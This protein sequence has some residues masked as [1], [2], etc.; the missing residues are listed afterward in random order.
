MQEKLIAFV[1]FTHSTAFTYIL[2]VCW[3][4]NVLFLKATIKK[5]NKKVADLQ[6]DNAK[7]Q[8]CLNGSPSDT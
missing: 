7:F 4:M 5:L 2:V 6:Q 1:D 3:L 8:R